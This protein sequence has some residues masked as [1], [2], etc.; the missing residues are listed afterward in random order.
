MREPAMVGF[1]VVLAAVAGF[2]GFALWLWRVYA[3]ARREDP[4]SQFTWE[5]KLM[6]GLAFSAT[7]LFAGLVLWNSAERLFSSE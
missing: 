7:L 5:A 6:F 2:G 1:L 3:Q 4:G